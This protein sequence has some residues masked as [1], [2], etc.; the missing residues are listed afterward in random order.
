MC[1]FVYISPCTLLITYMYCTCSYYIYYTCCTMNYHLPQ[2]MSK[3]HM[4]VVSCQTKC[5]DNLGLFRSIKS[6]KFFGSFFHY[7]QYG[8][9]FRESRVLH[10]LEGL[11]A[12]IQ[13]FSIWSLFPDYTIYRLLLF[14]QVA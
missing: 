11:I 4:D 12:T 2:A 8:Y 5:A 1:L 3:I 13:T 6:E 7:L 10:N 9:Y 14:M